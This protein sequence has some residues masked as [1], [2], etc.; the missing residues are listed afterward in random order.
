MSNTLENLK[1]ERE[2]I[3]EFLDAASEDYNV[4]SRA[5]RKF[6]ERIYSRLSAKTQQIKRFT[7][8]ADL[9]GRI[10]IQNNLP[11]G[12]PCWMSEKIMSYV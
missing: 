7:K 10:C 9:V 5:D 3:Y 12:D 8:N 2:E 1:R 11:G 6:F 4:S